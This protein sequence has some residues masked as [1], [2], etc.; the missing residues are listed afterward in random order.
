MQLVAE[1]DDYF[2]QGL[3]LGTVVEAQILLTVG[4]HSDELP[5]RKSCWILLRDCTCDCWNVA[6]LSSCPA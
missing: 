3:I 2:V 5:G 6:N 4:L 1:C